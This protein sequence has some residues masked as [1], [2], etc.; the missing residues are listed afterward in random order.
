MSEKIV[1]MN[2]IVK[3]FSGVRVLDTVNFNIYEGKIM[4]LIGENGAGKS[5][6]MKILTGVYTKTSGDVLLNGNQVNFLSTKDSQNNGIAI[7]HQELN[8]IQHLS[9]GENIFLG[10]EPV[11]KAKNI[12]WKQLYDESQK[13]L[14]KLGLKENPRELIKNLSVGKQQLVEIAKALSLNA[15]IIIMDEPT[16]ALSVSETEKLFCVIKELKVQGN[17]I[18]YISHRLKEIFEICD[19]VTVLRDGELIG[20]KPIGDLDEDKIIEMMVGRKLSEQYPRIPYHPGK[21]VLEVKGLTNQ[22]VQ[23]TSFNLHQGE[24]LGIAGLMGAGRTELVRTIYGIYKKDKGEIILNNRK[25]NIHNPKDALT[26]G[27]AYVS[28]DRKTNGIILGLNVRENITLAALRSYSGKIGIIK[29]SK[30]EDAAQGYIRSMS[31]KTYNTKQILKYLSGGNQQKVSLAKNLNT[32]PKVLI[33]D[34]PTRGVDVGAKKEIYELIN[35]FKQDGMSI[36]MISSEIP[37]I[38][39]MSDRIMVMHEGKI[40]GTLTIEDASQES[41]M[42]L[43]IGKEVS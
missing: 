43:A 9:I 32:N 7:I 39:G 37:E 22:Y 2:N 14:E 19:Y 8:L 42:S 4:A 18:V 16:G 21:I 36:I 30:E 24:I 40:T 10:R 26:Q 23:D 29:K 3:E 12:K 6:L 41:I 28:E 11:T 1:S 13:W 38:L 20:E 35:K 33:L 27:I 25:V 34:E 17:S 31:I 15:K 5:T